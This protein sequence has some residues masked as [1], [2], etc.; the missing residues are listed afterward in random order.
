MG[1][2]VYGIAPIIRTEK[3]ASIDFDSATESEKKDYFEA[4]REYERANPGVYFRANLWSW[5]PIHLIIDVVNEA[6]RLGIDTSSFGYNDGGG[7]KDVDTCK[8]LAKGIREKMVEPLVKKEIET[9]YVDF[10]SWRDNDGCLLSTEKMKE[11]KI[12]KHKGILTTGLVT[13]SGEIVYPS[14][15]IDVDYLE[16]FCCFLDECGGFEIW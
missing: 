8:L 3:P 16:Q 15:S 1:M 7:V 11:L 4:D 6:H 13:D 9:I 14:H 2:D 10:G 5:R 12:D